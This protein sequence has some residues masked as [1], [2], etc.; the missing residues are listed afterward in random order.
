MGFRPRPARS[1]VLLSALLA[2]ASNATAQEKARTEAATPDRDRTLAVARRIMIAARFCTLVTIGDLGQPQA[3]VVDPLEPDEAFAIYIATNP[4]SR[5]VAE[6]GKDPR[7]T[8]LYFNPARSAY[9]TVI[10]RA[11]EVPNAEKTSHRKKDWDTF[12]PAKNPQTYTL[13]RIVPSRLEVVSEKDGLS[14]DPVT[15]RPEIVNLK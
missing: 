5:K 9:V 1:F 4:R 2:F 3:R 7:V 6:I 10:G 8:L 11:T 15:W 14:G 12:F 13:Y